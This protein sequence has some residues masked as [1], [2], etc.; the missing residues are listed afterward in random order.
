MRKQQRSKLEEEIATLQRELEE[1]TASLPR[2]SIRA[3][4]MMR[5]EELEDQIAEKQAV[6]AQL[7]T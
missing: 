7:K 3:L 2:H 1:L 6:L 4:H 5:I